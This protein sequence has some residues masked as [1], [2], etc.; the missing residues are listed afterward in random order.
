MR[1]MLTTGYRLSK[2][3]LR[4]V[5]RDKVL[6]KLGGSLRQTAGV[7]TYTA[8]ILSV[9]SGFCKGENQ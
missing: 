1:V 8:T 7:E 2:T 9:L 3:G 5:S 6:Y 4:P